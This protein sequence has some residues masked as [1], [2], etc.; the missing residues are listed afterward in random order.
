MRTWL[1]LLAKVLNTYM[2]SR[3]NEPF[4]YAKL[5]PLEKKT[6]LYGEMNDSQNTPCKD[7]FVDLLYKHA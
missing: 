7:F 6:T 3:D 5:T 2:G 1:M 4:S